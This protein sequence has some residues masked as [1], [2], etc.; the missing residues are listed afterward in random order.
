M[1]KTSVMANANVR[2]LI[3]FSF[4]THFG[5]RTRQDNGIR[6]FFQ[7]KAR[8]AVTTRLIEGYWDEVTNPLTR[9]FAPR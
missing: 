9:S 8:R 1:Q 3:F 6:T 2:T 5:N 7:R 4:V